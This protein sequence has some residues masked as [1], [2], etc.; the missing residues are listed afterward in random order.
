MPLTNTEHPT[1]LGFL[2][3]RDPAAGRFGVHW[4][5]RKVGQRRPSSDLARSS[6]PRVGGNTARSTPRD[7]LFSY[8]PRRRGGA[9]PADRDELCK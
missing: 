8:G 2:V 5:I 9:E 4:K 1:S 7:S 3:V 6:G